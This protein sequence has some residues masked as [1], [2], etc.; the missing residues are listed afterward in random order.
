MGSQRVGHDLVTEHTHRQ[1]LLGFPLLIVWDVGKPG[2]RSWGF[3]SVR[4]FGH[5]KMGWTPNRQY[6]HCHGLWWDSCKNH[7]SVSASHRF[8]LYE[9]EWDEGPQAIPW[10]CWSRVDLEQVPSPASLGPDRPPWKFHGSCL[11]WISSRFC[12][13]FRFFFFLLVD[14]F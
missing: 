3:F 8:P 10:R 13:C 7:G 5:T 6:E 9:A 12:F 4:S 2:M 14:Q 1:L 11:M